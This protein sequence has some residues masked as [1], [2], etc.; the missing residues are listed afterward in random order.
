MA[1]PTQ[2]KERLMNKILS[3]MMI[4]CREHVTED[5][6][7]NLQTFKDDAA[8]FDWTSTNYQPLL[9]FDLSRY[10]VDP[11]VP[12]EKAE[13]PVDMSQAETMM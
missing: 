4:N 11:A 6:V 12:K 3:Q 5:Q 1:H 10:Q 13:G 8:T 7:I 9:N 2:H